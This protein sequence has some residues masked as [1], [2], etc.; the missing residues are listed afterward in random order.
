MTAA[1]TLWIF[2]LISLDSLCPHLFISALIAR[3]QAHIADIP[4]VHTS[5]SAS[6]SNEQREAAA[7][8]LLEM[9]HVIADE[10]SLRVS[11]L[12][13]CC[14]YPSPWTKMVGQG[15]LDRNALLADEWRD[16]FE[17]SLLSDVNVTDESD[18][19]GGE[20]PMGTEPDTGSRTSAV[21]GV[22][23]NGGYSGGGWR[24]APLSP[25]V[26]IGVV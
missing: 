8:W 12:R 1:F 18:A 25:R 17:A 21:H 7:L 26:P 20:L 3:L 24:R 11:T 6:R 2:L 16:M 4:E 22:N 13:F 23:D 5:N 15:L 14:L 9:D 10:D 19:A